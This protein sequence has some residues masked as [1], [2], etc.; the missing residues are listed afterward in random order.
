MITLEFDGALL[1]QTVTGDPVAD[2]T[3][4]AE[5]RF[6]LHGDVAKHIGAS[7]TGRRIAGEQTNASY[8]VGD[9]M[10]KF[11]HSCEPGQ[12]PDVEISKALQRNVAPYQ[13]HMSLNDPVHG[14][15]VTGIV[16][17]FLA[18]A[19]DCW[20]L[21]QQIPQD[22]RRLGKVVRELHE[23]LA[24][25]FP[26]TTRSGAQLRQQFTERLAL[27]Q[28]RS[29]QVGDF[30]DLAEKAYAQLPESFTVQRVHGD[31]HLGQILKSE[32]QFYVIDFEGEPTVPLATRQAPDSPMRDVAGMLRSFD[33]AGIDA[34]A[35]FLAG[36]GELTESD[37]V[38]LQAFVIDKLLYEI[39]Y[40][41]HHRPDWLHI[42]L[43]AAVALQRSL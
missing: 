35:E 2:I 11:F 7:M 23:D 16:S 19:K 33:Y 24:A 42:P 37:Q 12:H 21:R 41:T 30:S 10:W 5:T 25:V 26:T 27:F 17:Q 34:S 36:Y 3:S 39:D 20:E 38:L 15:Y 13:G 4:G 14:E 28:H 18:G 43:A 8:I 9:T 6:Q 31:L 1:Q 40:E 29:P 32:G 22:A